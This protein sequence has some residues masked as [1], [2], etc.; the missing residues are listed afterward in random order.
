MYF[1]FSSFMPQ[2]LQNAF[3]LPDSIRNCRASKETQFAF[4]MS[5][6]AVRFPPAQVKT[7]KRQIRFFFSVNSRLFHAAACETLKTEIIIKL[8]KS[9]QDVGHRWHAVF[10]TRHGPKHR[11]RREREIAGWL[12]HGGGGDHRAA[13][14]ITRVSKKMSRFLFA[15]R[16]GV[17][18]TSKWPS[19]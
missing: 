8:V 5:I 11:C 9:N 2:M 18:L 7:K 1:I 14:Q 12:L 17:E 16:P 6:G 4:G 19:S 15:L 3:P 13:L 10:R